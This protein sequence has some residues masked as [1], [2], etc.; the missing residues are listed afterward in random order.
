MRIK[1][2]T[3]VGFAILINELPVCNFRQDV[4]VCSQPIDMGQPL[5]KNV[6]S[7][8]NIFDA[9]I[10]AC[11]DRIN[12]NTATGNIHNTVMTDHTLFTFPT[13]KAFCSRKIIICEM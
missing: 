10:K 13:A 1:I 5:I 2:K 12:Y 11:A 6:M 4:I 3:D 8:V 9:V 7:L